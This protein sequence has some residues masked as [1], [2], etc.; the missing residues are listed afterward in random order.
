MTTAMTD[1]AFVVESLAESHFVVAV[2][3]L[4]EFHFVERLLG[5][6]KS[7]RMPLSMTTAT[8]D[9]MFPIRSTVFV[10]QLLGTQSAAVQSTF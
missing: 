3:V 6:Q 2:P 1:K 4:V 7:C 9:K 8:A 5:T 10:E